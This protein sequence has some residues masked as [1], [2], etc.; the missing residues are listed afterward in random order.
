MAKGLKFTDKQKPKIQIEYKHF[1]DIALPTEAEPS[2]FRNRSIQI[3][4]IIIE[5]QEFKRII[6]QDV[7]NPQHHSKRQDYALF[8]KV[9]QSIGE[10]IEKQA[11]YGKSGKVMKLD[12]TGIKKSIY[13]F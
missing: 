8:G 13:Y 5:K 4:K 11:K 6:V 2:L 1:F 7:T 12:E 10:E 3:M 9:L